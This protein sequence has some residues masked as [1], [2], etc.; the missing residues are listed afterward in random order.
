MSKIIGIDLG[1]TNSCVAV[2]EGG[3]AKVIP[4]PEGNRTTPSVVAFKNGERLVGEVAKRQAITNPNTI[5]SIK[6]HMGTDYK[7]EIEGKQYTPQE[8]SA[9]ILQYLK[10]YAEDYL[11]EPVT[12]AVITVPAYFND[13][14]RQ[15]TKDAGRIAGLEVERIINEPTAAALAYGLDKEEDQTILVYDLG[16]GT[17]DVSI[18]ELGDGVFEVKATAGDNHLGGDDFDQ[19]II[20]YLVNQFKQEHGIDLSKDKMAL[21]RLKDAAEKAKKELS[22]VTQTQISLPFISAN[23]NGPLHLE[24]TLTRA[25][26]EELSAHLVERTMG[27]V[28]QAL[29]DAGLTPADI[30]KV[31][32]V[33]GSTRIPAVQE[34]IK[35]E[36]GKEPHKGVNP[37]EVVAIGAA[38]QGG[39]IAGEVK[40]VVL[41]DVTPLSLGIETM[42]GVFTKLIERNTTIPTSKSQVF[43]TAAD[44]Q[45]TVDIHVLQGERP[46][47]ADNKTLGRF[48]LTGIPPAPRGVPQIEVTFDIDANGIVHVRA[49]DLGTN[50]EQSITIKSSSGLSEEEIQRMIKEA[51]ENAEAD[52][53][54]KEA[55]E[56]R[57]EA[58]QLIFTTEKTL[59]EVEGKVSADE[60]KKAQEAKDALK[61]ALEKNDIDDI[62]KKK[63]ALQEAVQQLSIKLYEQA[64]KQAQDAGAQAD[65]AKR[66]NVVDAEFEEVKDDK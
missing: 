10:S 19:V 61:A 8:I 3:E 32:L 12:R 9:I 39:V 18:L 60:I 11:G 50:K 20:D 4:N 52:R 16:G 29:Q 57:N 66:D 58:D 64:A 53:K 34:A 27:P 23:E 24:T 21:Q 7:V 33:G 56:L 36:L 42:G 44:N 22:G 48:Q 59:K 40:D 41:L 31:I 46:M 1:T 13:A 43:T 45:T 26:F 37:D 14:Q 51:E 2:L 15:A 63:D 65:A 5:I 30:D 49:K 62:R 54:R 17:F 38:I 47:A 55:A 25:K 28:R 35:R 6:R